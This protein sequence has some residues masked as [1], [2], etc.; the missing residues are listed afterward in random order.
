[1]LSERVLTTWFWICSNAG[2]GI[3][4]YTDG[5]EQSPV[6]AVIDWFLILNL[7]GRDLAAVFRKNS[8]HEPSARPARIAAGSAVSAA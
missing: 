3:H 6:V 2:G 8:S 4:S 1:M 7:W 5:R